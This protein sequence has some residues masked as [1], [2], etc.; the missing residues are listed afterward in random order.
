MTP[1][2]QG[3]EVV[4]GQGSVDLRS[5]SPAPRPPYLT[6]GAALTSCQGPLEA[7]YANIPTVGLVSLVPSI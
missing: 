7:H 4:L 2:Y 3:R 6:N 1:G 5:A